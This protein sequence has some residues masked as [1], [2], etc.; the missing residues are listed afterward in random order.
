[1]VTSYVAG[2]VV[3]MHMGLHSITLRISDKG[4]VQASIVIMGASLIAI[5]LATSRISLRRTSC[6]RTHG[7]GTTTFKANTRFISDDRIVDNDDDVEISNGHNEADILDVD[8]NHV[9]GPDNPD[10]LAIAR[11]GSA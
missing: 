7:I 8:D 6:T 3:L 4:L 5:S 1:M 10:N 2:L 9:N 11:V